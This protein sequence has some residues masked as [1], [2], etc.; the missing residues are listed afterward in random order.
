MA[1]MIKVGMADLNTCV[2]PDSITT[3]GL[4]SCVGIALYDKLTRKCGLAHIMLPDSTQISNNSNIA[5]FA[6]TA[7]DELVRQLGL[8]GADRKRLTAKIA[9][10]AQMFALSVSKNSI[11]SVGERNIIAVKNKL[12]DLGIPIIAEDTGANYGRTIV[13]YPETGILHVKS[14]GKGE[15]DI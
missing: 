2:S 13:F 3:I 10:G 11:M 5:Q 6:D 8:I 9:G 7:I 1:N 15:K 4:G 12:D 14:I